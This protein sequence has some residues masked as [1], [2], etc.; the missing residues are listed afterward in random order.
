MTRGIVL[1][2][3]LG[4]ISLALSA[5]TEAEKPQRLFFGRKPAMNWYTS[6]QVLSLGGYFEQNFALG[7]GVEQV[8]GH[9]W[10]RWLHT[11]IGF[12]VNNYDLNDRL[13]VIPVFVEVRG[14]LMDHSV[15]PHY[16]LG[17]GYG[18]ANADPGLG[19]TAARGGLALHTLLGITLGQGKKVQYH[20]ETGYRFQDV[21]Y[22]KEYTWWPDVDEIKIRYQR[23]LVRVGVQFNFFTPE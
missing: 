4:S 12:G 21:Q 11:G 22:T 23:L 8:V 13:I 17:V 3:L 20:I 18:F 7:L 10:S 19:I 1:A 2:L 6:T 14:Y 9:R 15:S 5:Q 16:A